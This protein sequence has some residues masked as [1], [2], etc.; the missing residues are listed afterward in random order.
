MFRFLA[1]VNFRKLFKALFVTLVCHEPFICVDAELVEAANLNSINPDNADIARV[2]QQLRSENKRL[3]NDNSKLHDKLDSQSAAMKELEK[4]LRELES[5]KTKEDTK[6]QK[7]KWKFPSWRK[8]GPNTKELDEKQQIVIEGCDT[9]GCCFIMMFRFG[10]F[11]FRQIWTV[12]CAWISDPLGWLETGSELLNSI[13]IP[14]ISQI[15]GYILQFL[16]INLVLYGT[17]EFKIVLGKLKTAVAVCLKLPVL[18]FTYN[19]FK[20]MWQ[21][22]SKI[23]TGRA[24]AAKEADRNT[25][26]LEKRI[27]ELE[28]SSLENKVKA[29]ETQMQIVLNEKKAPQQNQIRP[30]Q[31][32]Q[33]EP[34]VHPTRPRSSGA[35]RTNWNSMNNGSR[36]QNEKQT[37]K[38][39]DSDRGSNKNQTS[40]IAEQRENILNEMERSTDGGDSSISLSLGEMQPSTSNGQV[41]Q[42]NKGVKLLRTDAYVSG[43]KFHNFLVDTGSEVNILPLRIAESLQIPY[44]TPPEGGAQVSSFDGTPGNI[45]G[46][47]TVSLKWGPGGKE[48]EVEFLISPDVDNPII[49]FKTIKDFGITIV[50]GKSELRDETGKRIVVGP[51]SLSS[52]MFPFKVSGSGL[53]GFFDILQYKGLQCKFTLCIKSGLVKFQLFN[54]SNAAVSLAAKTFV[55]GIKSSHGRFSVET[56]DGKIIDITED[57]NISFQEVKTQVNNITNGDLVEQFP[58]VFSDAVVKIPEAMRKLEVKRAEFKMKGEILGSTSFTYNIERFITD[59]RLIQKMISEMLEN[60]YIERVPLEDLCHFHPLLFLPKSRDA[61]KLVCD[62]TEVNSYFEHVSRDLPR[63]DQRVTRIT[64]DLGVVSY[65]D[66]L[67]IGAPD[68]KTLK[69]RVS[70]LLERLDQ[71]GLQIQ[72]NKFVFGVTSVKFLGFDI[73]SGGKVS[74]ESYLKSKEEMIIRQISFKKELQRILGVFNYVRSHVWKLAEKTAELYEI[75]KNCP[76]HFNEVLSEEVSGKVQGVWKLI[77][78]DCVSV[79]KG[80]P[81][82]KFVYHL[83]TDWSTVAKG[84]YLI[85]VYEDGS[86]EAI[87]LGS[88]KFSNACNLSSFLGELSTIQYALSKVKHLVMGCPIVCFC[89]NIGTVKKLQSF[90]EKGEDVRVSRLY[91]WIVENVPQ[92]EFQYLPGQNNTAADFLSRSVSV[93]VVMLKENPLFS[94]IQIPELSENEKSSLIAKAHTGHWGVDKTLAHLRMKMGG[95]WKNMKADVETFIKKCETCQRFGGRQYRDTLEELETSAVGEL[96]HLDFMGPFKNRR[97]II[98]AMDNFSRAIEALILNQPNREGIISLIELWTERWG[99]PKT[100]MSDQA[101]V[102]MG[103]LMQQW[104]RDRGINHMVSPAYYPQGN[105]IVERHVR[106]LTERLRKLKNPNGSWM[107]VFQKAINEINTSYHGAIGCCPCCML[108]DGVSRSGLPLPVELRERVTQYQEIAVNKQRT[109]VNNRWSKRRHLLSSFNVGDWA[110]IWDAEWRT[111]PQGKLGSPWRGPYQIIQQLSRTI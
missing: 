93:A 80:Q 104:F 103:E 49:G 3:L 98:I 78:N 10:A 36:M 75:L 76:E 58:T 94:D 69:K 11:S 44:L 4:R 40:E 56:L 97:Y 19:V 109:Q 79:M 15:L 33:T 7:K 107:N 42:V 13:Q 23:T 54:F 46:Q 65:V 12:F 88:S 101:Q 14:V 106:T 16:L 47:I 41:N 57:R 9:V 105:G 18:W 29:L 91:A 31:H 27:A 51:M 32:T 26:E 70:V 38:S 67:L 24:G 89:D 73:K 22:L 81:I 62:L 84:Y 95:Y 68:I 92:V 34:I 85:R 111:K 72:K 66:D 2:N 59:K 45:C 35:R 100:V 48:K 61:I 28:K 63:V 21:M 102:F 37:V 43:R 55:L 71:Y 52:G 99:Q 5:L 1:Q 110:L 87:D 6:E 25:K 83:F 8:M 90:L 64:S 96:L 77:Y 60:N 50:G 86:K 39:K 53:V 30:A 74:V 82:G 20:F 108:R 17:M